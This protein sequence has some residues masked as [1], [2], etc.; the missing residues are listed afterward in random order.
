MPYTKE[1]REDRGKAPP[2]PA[3]PMMLTGSS[4]QSTSSLSSMIAGNGNITPSSTPLLSSSSGMNMMVAQSLSLAP[5][6]LPKRA[7]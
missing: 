3:G 2:S 5:P 6:P 4:P 7:G 1:W